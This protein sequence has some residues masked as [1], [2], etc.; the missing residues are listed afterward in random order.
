MGNPDCKKDRPDEGRIWSI[1]F[2][3]P[4]RLNSNG[5]TG[6]WTRRSLKTPNPKIADKYVEEMKDLLSHKDLW[7]GENRRT[8]A[9]GKYN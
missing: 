6:R 5:E 2:I 4:L 1:K 9:E 8:I 3:H 7:E